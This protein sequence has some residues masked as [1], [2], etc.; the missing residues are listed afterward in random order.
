MK[1]NLNDYFSLKALRHVAYI[2]LIVVAV[3]N[4][5]EF[6]SNYLGRTNTIPAYT[7]RNGTRIT[8]VAVTDVA[9]ILDIF[10]RKD[11]GDLQ[12][13]AVVIDIGANIGV[14]AIYAATKWNNVKV[15]GFEPAPKEF[16]TFADNITSNH[17][18]EHISAS[19]MAV[20]GKDETRTLFLNGGPHNSFH[21]HWNNIE[22][23]PVGCLSLASV[24][25]KND[26]VRCT[27]LK[28]DCEGSEFEIL[29]ATPQSIFEKIAAIRME[30]HCP[31]DAPMTPDELAVFLGQKGYRIVK[32]EPAVDGRGIMWAERN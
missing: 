8:T 7:F 32:H 19:S 6:L 29:Q 4:W 18:E 17:L 26:I 11:Y 25:K 12:D 2:P 24:F 15:F 1:R 16:S 27:M 20:T 13:D 21:D 3:K 31:P 23:L 28:M 9:T 5:S 14:Y 22:G 30:Y 10:F